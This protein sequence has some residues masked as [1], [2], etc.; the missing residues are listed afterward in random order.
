[1][2]NIS[3]YVLV[4]IAK[5]TDPIKALRE[6]VVPGYPSEQDFFENMDKTFSYLFDEMRLTE[7]QQEEVAFTFL[8]DFMPSVTDDMLKQIAHRFGSN[9]PPKMSFLKD[10]I[11]YELA[12]LGVIMTVGN[13]Y[14]DFN[15]K[16]KVQNIR[17]KRGY[18]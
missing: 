7:E 9:A 11:N 15:L 6:K 8:N 3:D 5:S 18:M 14:N 10:K 12:A 17:K 13:H 2:L 16:S 4:E 1:M